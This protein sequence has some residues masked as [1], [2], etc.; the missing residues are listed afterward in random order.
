MPDPVIIPESHTHW[1]TIK[2]GLQYSHEGEPVRGVAFGVESDPL[3]PGCDAV[4]VLTEDEQVL[5]YDHD[6]KHAWPR[7]VQRLHRDHE[8]WVNHGTT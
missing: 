1:Y 2:D 8:R 3:N 7:P 4:Q 5:N 6:Q